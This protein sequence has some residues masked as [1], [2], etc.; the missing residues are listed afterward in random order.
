MAVTVKLGI[1]PAFMLGGGSTETIGIPEAA[2][3]S[4][5]EGAPIKLVAGLATIGTADMTTG[6]VGFAAEPATTVTSETRT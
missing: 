1:R 5:F 6:I 4:F 2:S 3:Q